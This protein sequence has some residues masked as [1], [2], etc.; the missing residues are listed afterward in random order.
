[1][2]RVQAAGDS[3]RGPRGYE[4]LQAQHFQERLTLSFQFLFETLR[5]VAIATR[6]RFDSIQAPT[7]L[8]RVGVLD[9]LKIHI[10]LPIGT[11]LEEGRRTGGLFDSL[12]G[13]P[14]VHLGFLHVAR[15]LLTPHR[16]FS[17]CS[18]FNGFYCS[19]RGIG[20]TVGA[21]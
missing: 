3:I 10:P 2:Q 21:N 1:V 12:N 8:A 5:A 14:V 19:V 4:F 16:T 13:A 20:Y 17:Q 11:L 15:I 6:P 18:V 7:I 9:V